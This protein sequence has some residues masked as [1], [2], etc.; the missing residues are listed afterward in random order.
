L[1]PGTTRL[2]SRSITLVCGPI[3][4]RISLVVPTAAMRLPRTATASTS[5]CLSS[6]VQILPL[7]KTRSAKL[8]EKTAIEKA[9]QN[10]RARRI[11]MGVVSAGFFLCEIGDGGEGRIFDLDGR[12]R[13]FEPVGQ[14]R[15]D[16]AQHTAAFVG[17]ADDNV[18]GQH[19]T[20]GGD[21]PDVQIVDGA[22]ARD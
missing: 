9:Q 8:W 19:V 21:R 5:G 12:M 3:Q 11:F 17:A 4:L 13:E 2:P 15:A 20:V 14:Q 1:N 18:R 10:M 6:T 22:H 16:F 7:S